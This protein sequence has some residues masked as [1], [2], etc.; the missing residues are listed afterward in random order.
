MLLHICPC[1]KSFA[2]W[3]LIS[4]FNHR[5]DDTSNYTVWVQTIGISVS[6]VKEVIAGSFYSHESSHNICQLTLA[7]IFDEWW[8]IA[9]VYTIWISV[10]VCVVCV[11]KRNVSN[12]SFDT[13]TMA[14]LMMCI[15]V[16]Y[17]PISYVFDFNR[18]VR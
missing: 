17:T 11:R 10:C 3:V 9:N 6:V 16:Y 7:K 13:R 4:L 2:L 18:P 14:A 8:I 15:I 1:R 12:S 5:I